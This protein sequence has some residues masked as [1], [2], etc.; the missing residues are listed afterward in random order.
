VGYRYYDMH[1]DE[2]W[3]PFGHGLHYTTFDYQNAKAVKNDKGWELSFD[4]TNAGEMDGA[5][6]V[7]LYVGDPVSTV[8]KPVKELK[9]FEKVFVKAGETKR[10]TFQ[11]TDEDLNYYNCAMHDWV[12]ENGVYDLYL[13]ASS[14]DIR[15]KVSIE[16]N[17]PNSYPMQNLDAMIG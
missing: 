10:V 2:I 16:Y 1:T 8:S 13:C 14:Q 3:F 15:L 17:D 7:Q 6:V 4:L 12:V 11:I 9:Q 5:E